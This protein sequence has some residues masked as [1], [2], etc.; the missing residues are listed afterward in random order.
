ML[1]AR[2]RQAAALL[3]AATFSTPA[4]A[5]W[6][7]GTPGDDVKVIVAAEVE[8][9]DVIVTPCSGN[10]WTHT[11]DEEVDLVAGLPVPVPQG[12]WEEATV[13]F[14]GPVVLTVR[15]NGVVS[16][17]QVSPSELIVLAEGGEIDGPGA[18]IAPNTIGP[19]GAGQSAWVALRGV[20]TLQEE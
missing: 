8:V 3:I 12:C 15:I 13:T 9:E 18:Q 7:I 19:V 4:L 11:V 17:E 14:A 10:P 1:I 5:S 16:Q 20:L 2:S 6:W